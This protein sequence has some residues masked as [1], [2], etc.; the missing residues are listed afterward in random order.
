MQITLDQNQLDAAIAMHINKAVADALSSYKIKEVVA[1]KLSEQIISGAIGEALDKA[2]SQFKDEQLIA[3]LTNE[4]S[5]AVTSGVVITMR[6]TV[7]EMVMRLRQ[8]PSYD[9]AKK[10]AARALIMSE[11]KGDK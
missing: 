7:C 4:M 6:E 8:I 1:E 5:K 2:C 11:L 3:V 10:N 9:D